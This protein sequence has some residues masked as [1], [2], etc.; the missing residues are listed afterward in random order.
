MWSLSHLPSAIHA[1]GCDYRKPACDYRR[2]AACSADLTYSLAW[3]TAW[4]LSPWQGAHWRNHL[5]TDECRDVW[6]VGPNAL[7]GGL[8][9]C[10]HE[11][12]IL[13][14]SPSLEILQDI[15]AWAEPASQPLQDSPIIWAFS[16]SSPP[17]SLPF[18]HEATWLIHSICPFRW[19][20]TLYFIARA[21]ITQ[22]NTHRPK[23]SILSVKVCWFW[24]RIQ[25][26]VTQ[27]F[28]ATEKFKK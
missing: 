27:S 5:H 28:K 15:R 11:K 10:P 25:P 18:K 16:S 6:W 24:Y 12:S 3:H 22:S 8:C 23:E 21:W 1:A 19:P 13:Y 20:P 4:C 14:A 9:H 17:A 7:M 2:S 26:E